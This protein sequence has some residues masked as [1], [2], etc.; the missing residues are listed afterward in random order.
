MT[1]I[2]DKDL[3]S[4]KT[5]T[6]DLIHW[7]KT[8]MALSEKCNNNWKALLK[9]LKSD[10][11]AVKAEKEYLW[12]VEGDD[13]IIE[14]LL[15]SKEMTAHLQA[16]LNKVLRLKEKLEGW[17]LKNLQSPDHGEQQPNPRM[18]LPILN[19][20][21]FD[22]NLLQWQEFWDIFDFIVHQQNI[23]NVTNFSYLKNSI[24]GY[25]SRGY[26]LNFSG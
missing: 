26:M 25:N 11:K 3:E 24:R 13:G 5:T 6:K 1:P 23:S 20:P 18:G 21:T 22:G 15:D 12:A 19:L 10:P 7:M 4:D 14:L 2:A 17:P 8:N 9:E 16:Y